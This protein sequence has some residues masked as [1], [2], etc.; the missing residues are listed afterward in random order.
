MNVNHLHIEASSYCNARCPGCPR[1]GFGHALPGLFKQS[2]LDLEIYNDLLIK[3]PDVQTILF[4]GNHGDPMMHPN[5]LNFC[6]HKNIHYTIATNGGIG[7][8][9]TYT[10]LAKLPV[11]IIF[12]IDGLEDTNHLYRQGVSWQKLMTR[13]KTFIDAGGNATW[14][15]I[16]FQHNMDQV[17]EAKALSEKLGFKSFIP[18]DVGRNN[19]PA[20]QPDKTISHWILPPDKD[21]KPFTENFDVEKYLEMRMDANTTYTTDKKTTTINCEHLGGSIYINS[22][23]ELFPCCYHG[24]GH[25]DRPKVFLKDFSKLQ[26]TWTSKKC[27]AVCADTCGI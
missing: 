19:M 26:D 6:E 20:I 10:Q 8:S 7:L 17:A 21:A 22:S 9:E 15:F 27:D 12:G 1:N 24:F 3:Y 4:C 25:V 11:N 13:V 23:G 14:Q 18:M 2:H 16:R 5:I